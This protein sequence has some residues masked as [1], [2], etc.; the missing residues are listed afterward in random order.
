MFAQMAAQGIFR[1]IGGTIGASFA[2]S[3]AQTTANAG[4]VT[5]GQG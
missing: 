5:A 3:Q 4:V 1:N 2:P